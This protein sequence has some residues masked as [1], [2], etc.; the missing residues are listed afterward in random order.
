[1]VIDYC[2]AA[3]A[4]LQDDILWPDSLQ[5]SQPLIMD[6]ASA[7]RLHHTKNARCWST[8]PAPLSS[9]SRTSKGVLHSVM[10]NNDVHLRQW[11]DVRHKVIR[12]SVNP[13]CAIWHITG[14]AL[15]V[16]AFDGK[17]ADLDDSGCILCRPL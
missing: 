7:S 4:H 12:C 1:M 16:S 6:S 2:G 11:A 17:L 14:A 8:N 13:A 15:S 9:A 10:I 3:A 5:T